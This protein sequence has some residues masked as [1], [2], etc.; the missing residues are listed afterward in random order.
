[1]IDIIVEVF[2]NI[3]IFFATLML[4]GLIVYKSQ[5]IPS[6]SWEEAIKKMLLKAF[7]WCI[8]GCK[9]IG[10]WFYE[11]ATG[12]TGYVDVVNEVLV[13]S[14][15]EILAIV[16]G[17]SNHPYDTPSLENVKTEN[18]VMWVNISALRMVSA[19]EDLENE[20]IAKIARGK[21]Q[22]YYMKTREVQAPIW[23]LK[24]SPELLEFAIPLSQKGFEYLQNQYRVASAKEQEHSEI[25]LEE[26]IMEQTHDN[27]RVS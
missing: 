4:M 16:D 20:S 9:V 25:K 15:Q 7:E 27:S 26:E 22:N 21:I 8:K 17:L 10:K 24:A 2:V 11:E 19:Y 18:S 23:I 12:M 6:V 13:L 5:L 14:N 1:M 3:Y